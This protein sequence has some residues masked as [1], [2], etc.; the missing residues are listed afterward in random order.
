MK[1][2]GRRGTTLEQ[3]LAEEMKDPEFRR[4]YKAAGAEINA[5]RRLAA[6]GGTMP[7]MKAPRRR[8]LTWGTKSRAQS[9]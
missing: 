9:D 3:W 7:K 4:H 2:R 8:R 6:L 1:K 5:S